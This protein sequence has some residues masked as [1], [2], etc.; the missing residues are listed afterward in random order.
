MGDVLRVT[1]HG[2]WL[3]G[4]DLMMGTLTL[5]LLVVFWGEL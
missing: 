1:D 3:L 5:T 4:G 2:R